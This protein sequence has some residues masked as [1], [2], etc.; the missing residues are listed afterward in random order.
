MYSTMTGTPRPQELTTAVL[1][2]ADALHRRV[3]AALAPH[4]I[5]SQQ[6]NV[7]RILR[8]VHPEP[9]PTLEIGARMIEQT[10]GITRLLDR[11]E[12]AGLV[13]RERGGD[14][15]RRVDCRIT[16]AGRTLL[17]RTD[18]PIDEINRQAVRTLGAAERRSL[19]QM[20]RQMGDER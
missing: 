10:P 18:G 19:L 6:Y 5:T 12:A 15:R 8:G 3:A 14:D 13:R 1:R 7:L 9:L 4:G 11:L 20:L 2:T 17:A 16:A